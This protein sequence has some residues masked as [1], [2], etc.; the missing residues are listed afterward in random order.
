MAV[1]ILA[2]VLHAVHALETW[3]WIMV[4]KEM[5]EISLVDRLLEL[6]ENVK[7]KYK[8]SAFENV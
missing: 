7:K 1:R 8:I 2:G 3:T 6:M 4:M 5:A